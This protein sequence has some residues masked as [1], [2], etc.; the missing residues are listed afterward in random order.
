MKNRQKLNKEK[1]NLIIYHYACDNIEN[2]PIEIASITVWDNNLKKKSLFSRTNQSEKSM[3]SKFWK[4][5]DS[6]YKKGYYFL[7]WNTKKDY[8]GFKAVKERYYHLSKKRVLNIPYTKEFDLDE[9]IKEEYPIIGNTGLKNLALWNGDYENGY[10]NGL[11]E[12]KLLKKCQFGRLDLSTNKKVGF[13]KTIL[14]AYLEDRVLI[15]PKKE[16]TNIIEKILNIGPKLKP[17][18]DFFS[19]LKGL[20]LI[21]LVIILIVVATITQS[22]FFKSKEVKEIE[23][24]A[25]E[26]FMDRQ[27]EQSCF[28]DDLKVIQTKE[29]SNEYIVK[30]KSINLICPDKDTYP[31]EYCLLIGVTENKTCSPGTM[32]SK[33]CKKSPLENIPEIKLQLFS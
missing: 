18:T 17:F 10:I 25:K 7:G 26:C 5:I 4:F 23:A 11:D 27:K 15:K 12:I 8:Y 14:K 9:L 6:K 19:S 29:L 28:M 16:K 31:R 24:L 22:G 32:I 2:R 30:L 1:D 20:L 33:D 3:L 13:I 21:A